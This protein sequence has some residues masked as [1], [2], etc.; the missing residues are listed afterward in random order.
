MRLHRTCCDQPSLPRL[1]FITAR[2]RAEVTGNACWGVWPVNSNAGTTFLNSVKESTFLKAAKAVRHPNS[3]FVLLVGALLVYL[4]DRSRANLSD[5]AFL[6]SITVLVFLLPAA[7]IVGTYLMPEANA[8]VKLVE[9][10]QDPA[11]RSA[12]KASAEKTLGGILMAAEPL[13]RGFTYTLFAVL[14]SAIAL[15]HTNEVIGHVDI[16]RVLSATWLALLMGTALSVFP[17]TWR[18][19]QLEEVKTV[20]ES[21]QPR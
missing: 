4:A 20:H 19:L 8:A 13:Q 6:T 15:V 11:K 17:M 21:L 1:L 9:G 12:R 14:L 18:L 3:V 2:R 16:D 7:A 5:T 10:E